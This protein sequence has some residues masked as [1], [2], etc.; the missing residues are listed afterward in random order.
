MKL[1][2]R[3]HNFHHSLDVRAYG[4]F[5]VLLTDSTN[6]LKIR[7]NHLEKISCKFESLC[8]SFVLAMLPVADMVA[9]VSSYSLT[10]IL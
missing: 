6:L 4:I 9:K 3:V 10:Q 5:K 2:L 7:H 1:K 8:F